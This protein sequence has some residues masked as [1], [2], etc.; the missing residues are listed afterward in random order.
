[1]TDELDTDITSVRRLVDRALPEHAS[2]PL[3]PVTPSG[4]SNVLFRLGDELVVR[5]PRQASGSSDILFEARW[6]PVVRPGLPVA[7]P[8]I[9]AVVEPDAE[10][11]ARWSVVRW[12]VGRRPPVPGVDPASGF[13]RRRLALDLTAVI[14]S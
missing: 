5:L 12:M 13:H 6:L 3:R 7:A 1:M 11:P 10:F 4:S 2:L 9:V 14:A 8:E